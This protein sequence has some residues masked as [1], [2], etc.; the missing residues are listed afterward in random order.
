MRRIARLL[1]RELGVV[2][3]INVQLAVRDGLVYVLEANPRASR[4][5]PFISKA[6]GVP[7][8]TLAAQVCCGARLKDLGVHDGVPLGVAVKMPVFPFDRFPGV[9]PLPGPEMRSTGEVMGMADSF[10]EAFAKAA[11]GAGLGLPLAGAV[12]LSVADTDK[13][14]AAALAAR[15]EELGF[16]LLATAGTAATLARDGDRRAR[17][18]QGLRGTPAR[19]RPHGQRRDPARD[20]HGDRARAP[21]ATASRSGAARSSTA[22]PTS[23]RS[24]ARSP[25]RRRSPRCAGVP[26]SRAPCRP[27]WSGPARGRGG[28]GCRAV[29]S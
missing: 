17:R 20:Q 8:A 25:P 15:L 27:G 14:R 21:T 4:T 9:D 28:T 19:R 22:S 11:L 2:G 7:W 5:V 16:T 1:A 12:F 29:D 24:R 18:P 10:G 13:P 23:P 3:L 6:T 26:R